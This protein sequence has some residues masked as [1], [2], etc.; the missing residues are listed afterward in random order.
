[1]EGRESGGQKEEQLFST[2]LPSTPSGSLE[3]RP[4]LGPHPRLPEHPLEG[5]SPSFPG[6]T[7]AY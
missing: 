5:N 3:E 6:E 1:V 2:P 7:H 4:D